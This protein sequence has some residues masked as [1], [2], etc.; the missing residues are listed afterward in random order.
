MTGVGPEMGPSWTYIYRLTMTSKV[1]DE[2]FQ[3]QFF[4]YLVSTLYNPEPNHRQ[5]NIRLYKSQ[6]GP[7]PPPSYRQ[8]HHQG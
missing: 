5:G 1:L 7:S 6:N 4:V 3:N 8:R 2:Q